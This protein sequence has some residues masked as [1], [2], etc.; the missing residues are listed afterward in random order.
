MLMK[1]SF[2]VIS[3]I[4]ILAF[5]FQLI[6]CEME[7]SNKEELIRV[8]GTQNP[9]IK[10]DGTWKFSMTPPKEFWKP[11]INLG[12]WKDI[13]VPGECGMQGFPIK[14]DVPYVYK[15]IISI[16]E[17]YENKNIRLKFDGVYSFSR[18]WV[19][20]E[21]IREHKGG[22]TAWECD[23]T[24][25]VNPG[26]NAELTVEFIDKKDDI[27][28]GSGYAKHQIGGILRSVWLKAL[29]LNYFEYLYI[30]TELDNN[31][32]NAKLKV[33]AKLS[34]DETSFI[35]IELYDT[36]YNKIELLEQF[37]KIKN[38]KNTF[39]FEIANPLKWDAEHPNLYTIKTNLFDQ[40]KNLTYSKSE[41]IGF[42]EVKVVG[43]KM[44]VNGKPI[45][46]RG[47]CRH[48][49]HPLLGRTST[50][51]YDFKDVLLAKESNMN[52][53]RTSHYPPSETFLNY[54]DEYGIYVED[55]SAVCFVNT[56]R[57]K[58]YNEIKQSGP[59]FED[60]FLSQVEEMV[61]HHRNHPSVIIWS[62]G[63]ESKYDEHIQRSYDYIKSVDSTRP[64]ISSY[65]GLVPDSAKCYDILSMHYPS[66]TGSIWPQYGIG[67]EN[68]E[69]QK[70]PALFDEWAH[71][72]CYNLPTLRTD[73]NVRE[74]WGRS[75]DSMWMNIFE[76]EGGLGGAI[77]GYIDE[78]FMMPKS[79]EGFDDWWGIQE[80]KGGEKVY[81]GPTIGYGEWGIIDTWRRKKPEFW[82]TKKAYS[83]TKILVKQIT[84]FESGEELRIPIYNRFDHTNF[85]EIKIVWQYEKT[86]GEITDLTIEPH[87]KGELIIPENNWERNK[88]L[89]VEFLN[90]DNSLI[91]KY[92]LRFGK[93]DKKKIELKPGNLK[94]SEEKD[95]VNI[96]GRNYSVK[97]NLK[98]GLLENIISKNDTLIKSGPYLNI[99]VFDN[100][101]WA[102]VPFYSKTD[103]W[104]LQFTN[105]SL[106]DGIFNISTKGNFENN[107]TVE[108]KI[109]IDENGLL[110]IDYSALNLPEN[111]L[112]RE[113]GIKFHVG[114]TITEMNWDRNPYW[115][116]Y[117]D[118][119]LGLAQGSINLNEIKFSEYRKKPDHIWE[120]DG[121]DFY[122][123]GLNYQ[124][125][126][127]RLAISTKENIFSFGLKTRNSASIM[128]YDSG[129]KA[130]RIDKTVMG[131]N[132]YINDEW[133]YAS[134]KWGNYQK[135]IKFEKQFMGNVNLQ[136]Q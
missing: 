8:T 80:L 109:Q 14:H 22:F 33:S 120:M 135:N 46:L 132:L 59:E 133:D 61:H 36:S 25:F 20:G 5:L 87:E 130:C 129:E 4:L 102:T 58:G 40:N 38:G 18:V 19:N 57:M 89:I 9:T 94:I 92:K 3:N 118:Y 81:K 95:F 13:L 16:P 62:I 66:Y 71:V 128:V 107:L 134:L 53:I 72:A 121:N 42:R 103:N 17:D 28:Y 51:E 125:P 68:F 98:N 41:K 86:K 78:T 56:H 76:S 26:K 10:L 105:Y 30:D 108:Y 55:E 101:D 127:N 77:W 113:A 37:Q 90:Q 34:N 74:F 82:S 48:D 1:K 73:P 136:I 117:P 111:K 43:N 69:Y 63:N 126:L 112:I 116:I 44:L 12:D 60:Q 75:L 7:S 54:C 104:Q 70:M 21:F 50:P 39:T 11:N 85:N 131:H 123:H 106:H 119:H 83:P 67:L 84:E 2:N 6:G 100:G 65:P 79:M 52:F 31:Y 64:V 124:S 45:K 91:D 15:T 27:S 93:R 29:P 88:F 23:V 47:A 24:K 110:N 115:T 49:I 32:Q 97:L 96:L 35:G 114:N 99:L 122:Y